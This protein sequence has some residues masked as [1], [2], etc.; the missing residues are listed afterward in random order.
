MGRNTDRCRQHGGLRLSSWFIMTLSL[1][2]ELWTIHITRKKENGNALK[3]PIY[4]DII[5]LFFFFFSFV[6]TEFRF[7]SWVHGFLQ[8]RW[9][10]IFCVT[11]QKETSW[12][13]IVCQVVYTWKNEWTV[14]FVGVAWV[15]V[16]TQTWTEA[17]LDHELYKTLPQEKFYCGIRH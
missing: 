15:C 13:D 16:W 12:S 11:L 17:V 3:A 8:S 10:K 7:G 9:L 6:F 4:I 2:T 14:N 1:L 5:I